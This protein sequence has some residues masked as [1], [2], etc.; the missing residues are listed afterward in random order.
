[1]YYTKV[2]VIKNEQSSF[3]DIINSNSDYD[4]IL[5]DLENTYALFFP[6]ISV[7]SE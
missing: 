4:Y 2:K 6:L 5:C 1:M 3:N 7:S